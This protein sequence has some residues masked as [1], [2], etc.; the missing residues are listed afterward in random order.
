MGDSHS[1]VPIFW[2]TVI[3]QIISAD[4]ESVRIWQAAIALPTCPSLSQFPAFL[5]HG[6]NYSMSPSILRDRFVIPYYV[7]ICTAGFLS[8]IAVLVCW[9][10]VSSLGLRFS[11]SLLL[12]LETGDLALDSGLNTQ[13]PVHSFMTSGMPN[14]LGTCL[15]GQIPLVSSLFWLPL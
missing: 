9:P 8:C 7:V 15:Y 4:W 3:I 10:L 13:P 5:G 12:I 2:M 6:H 14:C 11:F 1:Q